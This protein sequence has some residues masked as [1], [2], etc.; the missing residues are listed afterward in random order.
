M[1]LDAS[2]MCRC[3]AEG[4]VALPTFAKQVKIDEEGFLNLDLPSDENGALHMRFYQ[5]M[6]TACQHHRM[7]LANEHIG[8]WAAYRSF[9]HAMEIAGLQHF[10]TLKLQLPQSN[11]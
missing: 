10:P 7:T 2:V 1:G 3:F 9:Q 6:E 11:G 5:W 4:K 8:N